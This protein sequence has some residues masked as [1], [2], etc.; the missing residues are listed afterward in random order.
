M[1]VKRFIPAMLVAALV[2]AC[3]GEM[4]QPQIS[5]AAL[6]GSISVD[7]QQ[8]SVTLERGTPPAE[9]A[10][11]VV[12]AVV[13]AAAINGG[14]FEVKVSSAT[15]FSHI[16]LTIPG[17]PDWYHIT[18]AAPDTTA[19]VLVTLD[20]GA[21]AGSME[22]AVAGGVN[23]TE[24]G[25]YV[26]KNVSVIRVGSGDVQ[27][28]VAWNSAADVDLH[29]VDPAGEEVYWSNRTSASGGE[30]DLDSNAACNTDQ[31][32]NENVVWPVGEAPDGEYTVRLDYWDACGAAQTDFVITVWVKGHDAQVFSGTFTG[33]GD[34]GGEGS[35]ILI[36]T[37]TK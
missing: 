10:A 24:T 14:T 35:G 30:L 1:F 31:P 21:P 27:V 11:P 28:S 23:T 37:F 33:A 16:I 9:N 15:A 36:T 25:P 20:P 17:L 13:P 22:L 32:R 12:D 6:V 4:S 29:V 7:G 34:H 19:K 26:T 8:A 3:K 5:I 2:S 18:L